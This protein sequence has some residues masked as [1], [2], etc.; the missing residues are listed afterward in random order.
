MVKKLSLEQN[1]VTKMGKQTKIA[2]ESIVKYQ[3]RINGYENLK[4]EKDHFEELYVRIN[5]K[6]EMLEQLLTFNKNIQE[7]NL[8]NKV[9]FNRWKSSRSH[10]ETQIQKTNEIL[11]KLTDCYNKERETNIQLIKNS[12]EVSQERD[13]IKAEMETMKKLHK[14]ELEKL[15]QKI[16]EMEHKDTDDKTEIVQ[17]KDESIEIID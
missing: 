2:E 4:K 5:A 15:Q 8:L 7:P 12:K 11:D 14:E 17:I 13:R 9:L 16:T 10:Y 3:Q 1:E 6:Y